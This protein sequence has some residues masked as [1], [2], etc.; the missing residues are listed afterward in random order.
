MSEVLSTQRIT[1][2]LCA[3]VA[4]LLE[5]EVDT[6]TAASDL[7]ADLC[8]ESLQQLELMTRVE[9]LMGLML[10]SETWLALVT[11]YDLA[12]YTASVQST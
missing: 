4:E 2:L 7:T 11:V 12:Q 3:L 9:Q 1:A 5:V 8:L 10:D 6:V